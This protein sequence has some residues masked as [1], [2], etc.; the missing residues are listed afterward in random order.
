MFCHP[1]KNISCRIIGDEV[2]NMASLREIFRPALG[3][4]TAAI[5]DKAKDHGN[6]HRETVVKMS[7]SNQGL[8]YGLLKES[9]YLE[10]QGI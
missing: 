1:F 5:G 7:L 3:M 6:I 8:T 10:R 4:D 9:D 2:N